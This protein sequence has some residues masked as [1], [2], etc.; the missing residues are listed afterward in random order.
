MPVD[1]AD[2]VGHRVVL[3]GGDED[4]RATG[5]CRRRGRPVQV[6]KP[7]PAT[8]RCCASRTVSGGDDRRAA[9]LLRPMPRDV[10]R[11]GASEPTFWRDRRSHRGR[12]VD[13]RAGVVP[14]PPHPH[15]RGDRTGRE[16]AHDRA[17][18]DRRRSG[19]GPRRDG[20]LP[21]RAAAERPCRALVLVER[22]RASRTASKP[23]A[24]GRGEGASQAPIRPWSSWPTTQESCPQGRARTRSRC[25]S[26][27]AAPA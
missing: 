10:E 26:T 9:P 8:S 5:A 15:L 25:F 7:G 11:T 6:A 24:R 16:R 3:V 1:L 18:D 21:A 12:R 13:P 22:H 17:V 14:P 20:G 2:R 23:P 27:A 19:R 4:G